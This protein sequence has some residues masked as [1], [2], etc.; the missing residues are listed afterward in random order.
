MK[1][2]PNILTSLNL[3]SGFLAIIFAAD[4]ELTVSAWLIL[5][6]M[7]FDFL[8]GLSARLLNAYSEIGKELDS[9][10]DVVSF[11][12]APGF[13]IFRMIVDYQPGYSHFLI[14]GDGLLDTLFGLI[15]LI[16]PVCA[17]LRLAKF[18]TDE[19]QHTSFKGLPTPASA[20]AVVSV[21][22][23]GHYSDNIFFTFASGSELI[24]ALI[25][26]V[27]SLLMVSR[28]PLMSLK[29]SHLR[30]GG[31][32]GRYIL[33]ILVIIIMAIWGLASSILIV[34]LY[35]IISLIEPFLKRP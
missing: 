18:N 2:I 11:G 24:L 30:P 19:S 20:L 35:I 26:I 28:L 17:A 5:V 32:K 25:T 9:L 14:H 21:V 23:A 12:V 1:H 8:D 29:T 31:N 27:L 34:P 13:I 15:P 4:G 6:A 22:L 10:A 7:V 33:V 3:V 16:M